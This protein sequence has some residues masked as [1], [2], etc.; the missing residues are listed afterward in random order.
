MDKHLEELKKH[1]SAYARKAIQNNNIKYKSKKSKLDESETI[2]EKCPE[3]SE[4]NNIADHVNQISEYF[5]DG[6]TEIKLL[7]N[8][9]EDYQLFKAVL[10]LNDLQKKVIA[11]RIL[12]E[13]SF[14]EIGDILVISE[15]RAENTYY[16][17][18]KKIRKMLGEKKYGF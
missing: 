14:K 4:T 9:I 15:K 17:A 18:I 13:K 7:L 1:F 2:Y 3:L 11:L 6:I 5:M 16:N 12:G 10:D 8:Q